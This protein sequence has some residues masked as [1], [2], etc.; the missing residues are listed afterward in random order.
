MTRWM[1]LSFREK[2]NAE[3]G[4]SLGIKSFLDNDFDSSWDTNL[5]LYKE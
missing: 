1:M 2:E 4:K 3:E 5:E